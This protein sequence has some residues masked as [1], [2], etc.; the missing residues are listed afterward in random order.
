MRLFQNCNLYPSY[1]RRLHSL[2][3]PLARFDDVISAMREDLY[4]GLHLLQPVIQRSPEAF[5]ANGHDQIAQR[6]WAEEH[7]MPSRVT[8]DEILLAQI[9]E[10]RTEVFYNLDPIT[11]PGPFAKGLPGHVKSSI[12][13]RAAPSGKTN[14]TGYDAI[15][16]NFP[17]ILAGFRAQGLRTAYISPAFDPGLAIFAENYQRPIDIAFVGSFSR[18]HL[19]R[20]AILEVVASLTKSYAVALHLETSRF[21][22]LA[23]FPIWQAAVP[24]RYKRPAQVLRIAKGPVFGRELF[25]LLSRSKIVINS[26]IDMAGC[27]RGNMRCFETMGTGGLL[28]TD[29]GIY[30]DGMVDGQTMRIYRNLN[31]IPM[32]VEELLRDRTHCS[33]MALAGFSMLRD[34][35]SKYTQWQAFTQIVAALPG[36]SAS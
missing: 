36:R 33:A 13:W 8:L 29:D 6:A 19:Q 31:E 5:L 7:C 25:E 26:S 3:G 20:T 17:G 18:H 16:C 11:F 32:L 28:L 10:H 24:A 4:G 21:T 23:E 35:Y 22:R 15:V 30:P 14:F 1:A 27:E 9:E 12:A 34:T 2:V